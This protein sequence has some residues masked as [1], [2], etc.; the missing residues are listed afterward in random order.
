MLSTEAHNTTVVLATLLPSFPYPLLP[1]QK[2]QKGTMLKW[3]YCGD[4]GHTEEE[5]AYGKRLLVKDM[6]GIPCAAVIY[7]AAAGYMKGLTH[8]HPHINAP[9]EPV[10][11][12]VKLAVASLVLYQHIFAAPTP[13]KQEPVMYK[14]QSVFGRWLFLTHQVLALQCVHEWFSVFRPDLANVMS[15]ITSGLGIFVTVQYF[16]LVHWNPMFIEGCK[17]WA[18]RGFIFREMMLWVHIPAA[19]LGLMDV[20]YTKNNTALMEATPSLQATVGFLLVYAVSYVGFMHVNHSLTGEWPYDVLEP[21]G[22][23]YK[24]WTGFIGGQTAILMG[25]VGVSHGAATYLPGMLFG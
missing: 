19:V 1:L 15:F 2:Q 20:V 14:A 23:C 21:L 17:M 16:A 13:V 3:V 12:A 24:K 6:I 5:K 9:Q 4:A 18:A 22:K 8:P 11:G 7:Y 10:T 25:F